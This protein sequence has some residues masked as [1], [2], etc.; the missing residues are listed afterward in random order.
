MSEEEGPSRYR[1]VATVGSHSFVSDM[2]NGDVG[3]DA[4]PS[5]M[6]FALSA[7]GTCTTMTM[8]VVGEPRPPDT[9]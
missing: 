3:S 2:V 8:R 1:T 5:P 9:R 6:E 7:L 4:V